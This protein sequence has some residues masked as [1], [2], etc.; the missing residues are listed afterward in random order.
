[1]GILQRS[2]HCPCNSN[3]H[4][5]SISVRLGARMRRGFAASQKPLLPAAGKGAFLLFDTLGCGIISSTNREL[6]RQT[7]FRV[8][9]SKFACIN[10]GGIRYW[11][12]F[13]K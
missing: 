2:L 7:A 6:Q 12:H 1:M 3:P 8:C 4:I 5:I 11:S 9:R 10:N 13:E